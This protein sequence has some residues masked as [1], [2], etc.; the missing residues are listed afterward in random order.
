MLFQNFVSLS[1]KLI[2]LSFCVTMSTFLQLSLINIAEQELSLSW[3]N[4]R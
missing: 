4:N 3:E 2:V 1:L